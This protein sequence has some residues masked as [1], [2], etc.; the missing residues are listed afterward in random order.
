[1]GSKFFGFFLYGAMFGSS[2]GRWLFRLFVERVFLAFDNSNPGYGAKVST[3][4]LSCNEFRN[5]FESIVPYVLASIVRWNIQPPLLPV[6]T[7]SSVFLSDERPTGKVVP[8]APGSEFPFD[9]SF[10]RLEPSVLQN[11]RMPSI[12][13]PR[14]GRFVLNVAGQWLVAAVFL[15]VWDLHRVS[16]PI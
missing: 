3:P 6:A 13:P 14:S 9:L 7:V 15:T 8:I 1:M 5:G 4:L 16:C 10:D 11:S 2:S 12:F